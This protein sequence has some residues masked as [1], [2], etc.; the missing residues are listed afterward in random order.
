M[1]WKAI[2]IYS[3]YDGP[4]VFTATT[5]GGIK[6]LFLFRW[7]GGTDKNRLFQADLPESVRD[8]IY[9]YENQFDFSEAE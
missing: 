9:V 4:M 5:D 6:D 1:K 2:S 7:I 3:W 8:P